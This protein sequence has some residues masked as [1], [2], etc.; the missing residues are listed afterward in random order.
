MV[1]KFSKI[2]TL[3]GTFFKININFLR[4]IMTFLVNS[5]QIHNGSLI[6]VGFIHEI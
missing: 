6:T 2:S 3:N 1:F 4:E 5:Y